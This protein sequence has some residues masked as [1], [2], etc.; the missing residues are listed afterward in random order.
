MT[1]PDSIVVEMDAPSRTPDYTTDSLST[2][3]CGQESRYGQETDRDDDNVGNLVISRPNDAQRLGRLSDRLS[4]G[5]DTQGSRRQNGGSQ[6]VY[7]LYL[8]PVV[9]MNTTSFVEIRST[10]VHSPPLVFDR[11]QTVDGVLNLKKL[12]NGTTYEILV[13]IATDNFQISEIESIDLRI[14]NQTELAA[15]V[16]FGGGN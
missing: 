10:A 16:A 3:T 8:I 5:N 1:R 13:E 12:K 7:R 2:A 11:H 6:Q 14:G 9:P 15:K 4:L